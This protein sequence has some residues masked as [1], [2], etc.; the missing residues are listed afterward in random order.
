MVD[1]SNNYEV[2][3]L[4]KLAA[5]YITRL[6]KTED[7]RKRYKELESIYLDSSNKDAAIAA[8]LAK[9]IKDNCV[10]GPDGRVLLANKSSSLSSEWSNIVI[11][12][13]VK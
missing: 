12:Q 3:S 10:N 5:E 6:D 8:V 7:L 9:R 4:P 13:A 1:G 2:D 11:K